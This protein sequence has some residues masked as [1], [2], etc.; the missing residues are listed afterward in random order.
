MSESES[1]L[2][3]S[4]EDQRLL[5]I[6]N[7][8]QSE[9]GAG[10]Y[11]LEPAS[12]DASFRRYFRTR[13]DGKSFIVMDAPPDKEDCAPFI[14]VAGLLADAG[15]NAPRVLAQDS[16]QG[17]LLLSDMGQQT[18]MD[19]LQHDNPDSFMHDAI[20]ALVTWQKST[21]AGV[22]PPYD[23]ELLQRELDLFPDWYVGRHLG[24]K[25]SKEQSRHW[26]IVCELLIG[27]ALAQPQVYVHRDY[28]PRNLMVCDPNPGILDFQDAVEGP[29]A[30]DVLSLFKD[31]FISWSA[32][33][34]ARWRHYYWQQAGEAGLP[35]G[36]EANF[37]RAFDLIG[38]HRHL[39]VI[40]IFARI[41]HRDGKPHYLED[42]PRF[43]GYIC[44]VL[45]QYPELE[46][47]ALLFESLGMLDKKG[48]D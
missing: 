28:M 38:L 46:P 23:R 11:E 3:I 8:L 26:D 9:L 24:Y 10:R 20:N 34:I 6:Q 7:W 44:D 13:H 1:L 29:I 25:L 22:L 19:A 31:A 47:L 27:S 36:N 35:V 18:Y 14:T 48:I 32:D 21:R 16:A 5:G 41:R 37:I 15:L 33:Q 43:I 30:Y 45:P 2:T 42:V 4:T 17:F 12:A 40:G 39:K